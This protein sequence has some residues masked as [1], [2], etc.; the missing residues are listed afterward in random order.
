[1]NI[2]QSL[3]FFGLRR[4]TTEQA[5]KTSYRRKAFCVH[6]DRGGKESDF[7]EVQ[8]TFNFLIQ[9]RGDWDISDDY[10]ADKP[11]SM[12]LSKFGKGLDKT[13]SAC[14]CSE[15]NGRGFVVSEDILYRLFRAIQVKCC[16]CNGTG[17]V[18]EVPCDRCK[19]TGTFHKEFD[20]PCKK[21]E[22][23]GTFKNQKGKEV[24]CHTCKGTGRFKGAKDLSCFKCAGSGL[25]RLKHVAKCRRCGGKGYFLNEYEK[26]KTINVCYKCGGVGEIELFNPVFPRN[27]L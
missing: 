26:K 15:C 7:L 2:D 16:D 6:P 25:Y 4:P 11:P 13:K 17:E 18:T 22:G 8:N 23:K 9:N 3:L 24:T 19:G 14:S 27:R 10:G 21:C 1:M 12:D 20:E 5:L